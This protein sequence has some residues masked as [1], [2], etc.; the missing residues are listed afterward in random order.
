M[1]ADNDEVAVFNEYIAKYG[2]YRSDIT[3]AIEILE[4]IDMHEILIAEHL[5][6]QGID[7]EPKQL[8][9]QQPQIN[10]VQQ[11]DNYNS[12]SLYANQLHANSPYATSQLDRHENSQFNYFDASLLSR[13]DLPSFS[14]NLIEFPEFWSRYNTLVHSKTSLSGATK[15]SLLKSCLKGRAL[16]CVEGLPITDGDYITAVDILHMTYDNPCAMRHLI[17]TQLSNLPQCDAEGKQLQDI[18]LKMLRLVRQYTSITPGSPE[19]GLGALLYN[20]LPK[21]VKARIYDKTGAKLKTIEKDTGNGTTKTL[22]SRDNHYNLRQQTTRERLISPWTSTNYQKDDNDISRTIAD[23]TNAEPSSSYA[24]V[25]HST[26]T[27]S[28]NQDSDD[29]QGTEQILL[30]CAKVTVANP[31]DMTKQ[32][33]TTAF[34]DSGSSHSYITSDV[35]EYLQLRSVGNEITL[36]TFGS[37]EPLSVSSSL[38]KVNMLLPDATPYSLDVQSLPHLTKPL[39]APCDLQTALRE[40]LRQHTTIYA[41]SPHSGFHLLNTRLEQM[42]SG[43]KMSTRTINIAVRDD[44]DHPFNKD[45]LD[46]MVERFWTCESLGTPNEASSKDDVICLDFFNNTTRYDEDECRYYTRLP[47]KSEP[48]E[49]PENFQY[50]LSCLR[51]NWKTLSKDPE[52]LRKYHAIIQDQIQRSIIK[53]VPLS[54]TDSPG[55]F[56][57]HHAVIQQSKKT[58]KIRLVYNG[59]AK[60]NGC[61]VKRS[62]LFR[63]TQY[64]LPGSEAKYAGIRL[65]PSSQRRY[66]ESLPHGRLREL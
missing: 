33:I 29:E 49:V 11:G 64:L 59:S 46:K 39:M 63:G 2:D 48:P 25:I 18:Y 10:N 19:Y 36:H 28:N 47:F 6:H 51:S 23:H 50:S 15:F 1:A 14:G 53:E 60:V 62:L 55:T 56:L 35:A 42:I 43:K 58:T 26:S 12:R 17:Y 41:T 16:Q 30:M 45:A 3:K 37:R 57:S 52:H 44:P 4:R 27:K 61:P 13:L 8:S 34:L 32:L 7:C 20:K 5:A 65:G 66:R 22:A 40:T 24:A 54:E 38:H 21:F 31:G 9:S